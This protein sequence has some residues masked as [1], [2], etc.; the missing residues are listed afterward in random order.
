M[1]RCAV[2]S[3]C[4]L[5]V[6]GTLLLGAS[7][8]PG[9]APVPPP[10]AP[11][12]VPTA[13]AAPAAAAAPASQP[14]AGPSKPTLATSPPVAVK[15]GVLGTAAYGAHYIARE[16]GYFQEVGVIPE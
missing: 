13:G 7:C 11:T 12:S 5:V 4:I 14:A 9:A 15:V 3:R 1:T 10:T 2:G 8:A 6:L 16:R